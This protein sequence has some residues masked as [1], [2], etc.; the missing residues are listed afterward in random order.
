MFCST[1]GTLLVPKKTPYGSWMSCPNHHPQP[2]LVQE[3][4]TQKTK[5]PATVIPI[6][7]ASGEN[8]MAVYDHACPKC[9]HK[10]AE[11]IEM[12]PSYADEDSTFR[13]KCGKCGWVERLEGKMK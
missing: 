6:G 10:K 2:K 7:V 5:N 1:C 3:S 9:G 4:E 8:T 11:L 13:M 12:G